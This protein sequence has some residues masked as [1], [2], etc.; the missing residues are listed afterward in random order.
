[1]QAGDT[2]QHARQALTLARSSERD[3]MLIDLALAQ[4]DLGGDKEE[5]DKKMA[6][7]WTKTLE[8]IRQT[9]ELVT[10]PEAR[11]DGARAVAR[12]LIAKG[13]AKGAQTLAGKLAQVK[14]PADSDDV[15]TAAELQA[16][17]ALELLRA[18]HKPEAQVLADSALAAS[19]PVAVP[20]QPG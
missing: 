20:P 11:W 2:F 6:L 17:V 5:A 10:A 1:Q 13:Q 3:L 14:S 18:D 12:K 15:N 7:D 8:G 9:L 16:V 4:V 19:K